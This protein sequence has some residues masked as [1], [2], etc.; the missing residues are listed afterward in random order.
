MLKLENITKDYVTP[1]MT[2]Q[3]LKGVSLEFRK[4]EFVSI[5]GPS[6][7]GKTTLLNIVGG[8]DRYTSGDLMIKHRSTKDFKDRDWDK[9]RNH[10]VGFVFQSYNL[11][12]HQ[13]VLGNVELS[14]TI[15]GISKIERTER[16]KAALDKVGLG[17]QY[18]KH[19][20]Q[21]SG[22]QMQRVAIA[23]ALVND[24]E[25]ILADE[26]TGALDTV[27]S[28]QI[29]E[30]LREVAKERLVIMVTHNGELANEYS[31]RII[32][33]KDGEVIEDTNPFKGLT[34][35]QRE[36]EAQK[37]IRAK[38]EAAA[39]AA[40][41]AKAADSAV[42]QQNKGRRKRTKMSLVTA[43]R[44]SLQNLFS[45]RRRSI[46]VTIA[47][48]IGIIGVSLVLAF[49]FGIQGFITN[50]QRDMLSGNPIQVQQTAF[51]INAMMS[52][53][54]TSEKVSLVLKDGFANIDSTVEALNKRA[55]SMQNFMF[56]NTI[57]EDYLKFLEDIENVH[58]GSLAALHYDYG[59]NL[60][61]NLY[62]SFR[63][64]DSTEA[65]T[66]NERDLSLAAIRS[67][68]SSMLDET[69]L[70]EYASFVDMVSQSFAQLPANAES[71]I[72]TQYNLVPGG[73][74]ASNKNEVMIVLGEDR[75]VSDLTLAQLGYYSQQEFINLVYSVTDEKG[76]MDPPTFEAR[77]QISYGELL[78]KTF[79]WYKNDDIFKANTNLAN[80]TPELSS[81]ANAKLPYA[82]EYK[83]CADNILNPTD[84]VELTVVGILEPKKNM[85]FGMLSNGFYYTTE[86]A[87]YIIEQNKNSAIT[88][89]AKGWED[90]DATPAH[91]KPLLDE[92]QNTIIGMEST[93]STLP[94]GQAYDELESQ[95]NDLQSM[96]DGLRNLPLLALYSYSWQYKWEG[97]TKT[98]RTDKG[99][100]VLLNSETSSGMMGV[101]RSFM[102]GSSVTQKMG[103]AIFASGKPIPYIISIYP[104]SLDVKPKVLKYLDL[105]NS[106]D[107]ITLSDG[108]VI[109]YIIGV[110]ADDNDIL[111]EEIKYS[112]VLSIIFNMISQMV[113]L[114][115]IALI[116]FTSLALVVS[117]V[118]IGI[119]TYVS[120]VERIKEIG[121]IR[122]LGGRKRDVANLFTAETFILGLA[123]GIFGVCV[124][125]IV[126]WIVSAIVWSTAKI[127]AIAFL[128]IGTAAIM[129]LLSVILTTISG[130]LPSRSAARKDPVVALRTE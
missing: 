125:W 17:D 43:F 25:I 88:K 32:R 68:F 91:W 44:L 83:E 38:A 28:K 57:T 111:R 16:A 49:S 80:L 120:V 79:T 119:I 94:P 2:V 72:E 33:L 69:K 15:A 73:R 35:A 82:F 103:G 107:D 26:P 14:L 127:A 5:L 53:M 64:N 84:N 37:E 112:D 47:G 58:P 77:S 101:L 50:M 122:S 6:G 10:S 100:E 74:I 93:L 51:D 46:M 4:N 66:R 75:L 21:L 98:V 52:S 23:R 96:V 87:E 40:A 45:K 130:L 61:T 89:V 92:M 13:T 12:P 60:A 81:Y 102:G 105:W 63:D 113:N 27:T 55:E 123:A 114:V 110:D 59:L 34:A 56:D 22:G 109:K 62:T 126:S 118:M 76:K 70:G 108:T 129:V 30:L 7:C 78:G 121:V 20:N 85:S 117:S 95:I 41:D 128:P 9:Y 67:I 104:T 71:Y 36:Q 42:I 3:A 24:P 86:L 31:S 11:I 115:T 99:V 54:S 97:T 8:L 1:A 39:K 124:T 106:E 18:R 65:A 19:P 116:A 29:M 90:S 48:S